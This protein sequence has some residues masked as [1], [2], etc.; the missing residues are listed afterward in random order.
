M[1]SG[2]IYGYILRSTDNRQ[3]ER[4]EVLAKDGEAGRGSQH[5]TQKRNET[6]DTELDLLLLAS[7]PAHGI[8][9]ILFYF[10]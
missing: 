3:L 1:P 5:D 4:L 10:I 7:T 2:C 6:Q 9:G 8:N